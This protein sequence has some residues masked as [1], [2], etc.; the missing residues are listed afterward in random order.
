MYISPLSQQIKAFKELKAKQQNQKKPKTFYN[1]MARKQKEHQTG[2]K[3][4]CMVMRVGEMKQ[5]MQTA[6]AKNELQLIRF[7]T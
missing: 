7:V 2:N 3:N 1:Q 6:K 5:K 4:N